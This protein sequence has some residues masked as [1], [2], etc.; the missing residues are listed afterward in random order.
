MVGEM[1][2]KRCGQ[3]LSLEPVEGEGTEVGM[4]REVYCWWGWQKMTMERIVVEV[5]LTDAVEE[6]SAEAEDLE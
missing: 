2:E 5:G 3:S 6:S 1:E 4:E